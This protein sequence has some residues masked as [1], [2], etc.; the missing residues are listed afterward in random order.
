MQTKSSMKEIIRDAAL[1]ISGSF[2]FALGVDYF[3]IPFDIVAGGITGL[4]TVIHSVLLEYG[5]SFPIGTQTIVFNILLMIP[6]IKSGGLKYAA[7]TLAGIFASGFFLDLLSPFVPNLE[8]YDLFVAVL[9]GGF[10]SGIGL[11]LVFRSGGNTGGTDI[12]AQL[13][14]KKTSLPVGLLSILCDAVVVVISIPVFS[15]RNALYAIIGMVVMGKTVDF[16]IEGP[17]TERAAYIISNEHEKIAEKV[18]YVMG[19]GCT[20]FQARGVWSGNNKPVL[21]VVLGL[22]EITQLKSIVAD[23]DPSAIVIISD[24]HEAFGEGFKRI[25]SKS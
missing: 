5:I 15:I 20:E 13:I 19:R 22:R 6:V 14:S 17:K 18:M 10:I 12:I 8:G 4:A 24:V 25:E 7:R 21:F 23:I 9:W 16:I 2:I 3:L 11:G 1:I